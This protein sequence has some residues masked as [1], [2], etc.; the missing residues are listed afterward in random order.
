MNLP[1]Y[2]TIYEQLRS[3]IEHKDYSLNDSLPSEKELA[4]QFEVSTI[5]IKKALNLLKEDGYIIRKPRKGSIVVSYLPTTI[6]TNSSNNPNGVLTLGLIITNFTDFF[7]AHIL[8]SI[9]DYEDSQ[10][11]F[12]VKL[13]YGDSQKEDA[14][15]QELIDFGIQGLILLPSSSEYTSPKILELISKEFPMVVLDR[16]M[17]NLPICSVQTDSLTAAKE[18]T[19]F[20]FDQGHK[21][22]GI[23]TSDS[24]VT[25]I[26]ERVNGFLAAHIDKNIAVN[27]GQILSNIDSV[28]PNSTRNITEDVQ[29]IIHFIEANHEMTAI[30]TTEYNIALLVKSAV[31]KLG[32]TIPHDFSLVCF[33]HPAVNIF[34]VQAFTITHIKQ[35]QSLIGTKA[36]ELLLKKI[37]NPSLI[38]KI[39][40]D[41][42]L[43]EGNSVKKIG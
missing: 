25:T 39:S 36:V 17:A 27:Q 7:G 40:L 35:K 19:K 29:N 11:H 21:R 22:I 28:V 18:L 1:L 32:Y 38:E 10:L 33:D 24:H 16:L 43:V 14:L 4:L 2:Q 37:N 5:T 12:I 30:L 13:S 20:L 23:I 6:S 31:E 8:R 34:D 26:D 41:Y 42:E 9:L 15:I 3:Q